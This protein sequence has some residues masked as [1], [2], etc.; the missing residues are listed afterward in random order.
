M[1]SEFL[2]KSGLELCIGKISNQKNQ[3]DRSDNIWGSPQR[4]KVSNVRKIS[5]SHLLWTL[6]RLTSLVKTSDAGSQYRCGRVDRG[7][8]P[9]STPNTQHPFQHRHIHKKHQNAHFSIFRLVFTDQRSNQRTNRQT[10][11]QS[12]LE[13]FVSA[14]RYREKKSEK[15]KKERRRKE[16]KKA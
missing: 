15:W 3:L 2:P 9:Q 10:D 8:Q 14:T 1:H 11:G 5:L 16:R 12:L 13:S 7:I 6:P 4:E